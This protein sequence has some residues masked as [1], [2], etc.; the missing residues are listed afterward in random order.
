YKPGEP[1]LLLRPVEES[2]GQL[3]FG[4]GDTFDLGSPVKRVVTLNQA[5]GQ[6][7]L[8]IFGGGEKVGIFNFDGVKAPVSVQTINS[9]NDL[10]NCAAGMPDGFLL[11]SQTAGGKFSTRYHVYKSSG[12]GYVAGIF[13]S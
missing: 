2:G 9:T 4:K 8:V 12:S 1:K 11:F 6:K 3:Q 10:M 7:L 13:G 5:G